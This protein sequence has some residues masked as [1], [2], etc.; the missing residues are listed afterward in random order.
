MRAHVLFTVAATATLRSHR[1]G[2]ADQIPVGAGR[3]R[4]PAGDD[5]RARARPM[6]RRT[7]R[8]PA[9]MPDRRARGVDTPESVP[10][11]LRAVRQGGAAADRH[12]AA[13]QGPAGAG[14]VGH[15]E[16]EGRHVPHADRQRLRLEGQL[17]RRHA[18]VPHREARL[19]GGHG[20]ARLDDVP[21][22][23]RP[24]GAVPHRQRE[25]AQAVPDRL[26]LRH[27]IDPADRRRAVVRRRVRPVPGQDRQERQGAGGVR[28]PRSTARS[29]ARPTIPTSFT[30][31]APG[32]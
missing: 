1:G 21:E 10:G 20:R 28:R 27:R 31:G 2:G 26:G 25:H 19:E 11:H 8:S 3:P 32:R 18:D 13:V 4:H 22:R 6:R 14:P 23:P 30:P 24:Q 17:A 16:P 5:L 29:C 9:A 12:Q 15:Q 7:C